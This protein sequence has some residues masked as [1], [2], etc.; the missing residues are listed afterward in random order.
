VNPKPY[1]II[2]VGVRLAVR[3]KPRAADNRV[4]GAVAEAD[5]RVA[6]RIRLTAPPVEGAANAALIA[7]LAKMLD[8]RQSDISI[9]SGEKG[10]FKIVDLAGNAVALQ[11]RLVKIL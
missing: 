4:E 5:G 11:A 9:R 3:L 6:L 1:S 8:M 10:R 7:F 2:P